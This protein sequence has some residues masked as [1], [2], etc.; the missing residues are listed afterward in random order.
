MKEKHFSLIV[1]PSI[2]QDADIATSFLDASGGDF[3]P[4][5]RRS[6][7]HLFA[8]DTKENGAPSS[9]FLQGLFSGTLLALYMSASEKEQ[10]PKDV[11]LLLASL[12]IETARWY[13]DQ[14]EQQIEQNIRE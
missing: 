7:D 4:A 14:I 10:D 3:D 11:L 2:R 8:I 13:N 12:A 1:G 9:D 6:M 5:L